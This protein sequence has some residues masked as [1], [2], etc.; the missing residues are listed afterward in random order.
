[1]QATVMSSHYWAN[2]IKDG[3]FESTDAASF[4]SDLRLL[5]KDDVPIADS[6]FDLYEPPYVLDISSKGRFFPATLLVEGTTLAMANPSYAPAPARPF[7]P[8][9]VSQQLKINTQSLPELK[10]MFGI[11]DGSNMAINLQKAAT[12]CS[13][14]D[15]T[16][17]SSIISMHELIVSKL[18]TGSV[19]MLQT[20]L[21]QG[22]AS[23]FNATIA[24]VD[25]ISKTRPET[26]DEEPNVSCHSTMFPFQLYSCHSLPNTQIFTVGFDT[27]DHI[28][29][30]SALVDYVAACH[31]DTS[32]WNANFP[33][34]KEL[35]MQPGKG[36]VCHWIGGLD[37]AW[38]RE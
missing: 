19:R 28:D 8:Y 10:K 32:T 33:A 30:K 38:V 26:G 15:H 35:G 4:C 14:P 2:K 3:S 31:A 21:P 11:R 17:V 9:S 13:A 25:K 6:S 27:I 1:M 37:I 12:T 23:T 22:L 5:C 20:I 34:F 16:C 29:G 36:A 7:L 18:G 24:R